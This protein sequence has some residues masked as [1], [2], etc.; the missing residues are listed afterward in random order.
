M[1]ENVPNLLTKPEQL[2]ES[3]LSNY[4]QNRI[5]PIPSDSIEKMCKEPGTKEGSPAHKALELKMG[6]TYR[7]LLGECMYAYITCRP[8]IGYAIT[9]LSKFSCAPGLYHYKLLRMVAKYLQVTAH[10]GI[11]F[12][13]SKPLTLSEDDY[14]RGFFPTTLYDIPDDPTLQ[15]L[16]NVDINTNKLVGFVDAAH[17]NDLRKR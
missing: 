5:V 14:K 17:A 11:W 16:F 7:T 4:S 3:L 12:K 15:D 8:D 6:F 10:W 2:K 13:R 1:N 9:T